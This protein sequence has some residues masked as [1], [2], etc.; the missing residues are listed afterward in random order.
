MLRVVGL[1]AQASLIA[2]VLYNAVTA[3]WGWP[4][5]RQAPAGPRTRQLRVVVPAHD[6]AVVLPG[7]LADLGATE[8]PSERLEVWVLA[9]RCR[10][11]TAELARAAGAE[12]D[13][14]GEGPPGKGPA[15]AW[16]LDRHPLGRG[17]V[18][19]VFDAD[20][21]VP[22]H[23]LA[24]IADEIDQGHTVVQCYLDATNPGASPLAEA[25]ALSYWAGNRMVQLARTNL[26]W[27][28]D[29]GG[30]G[31]AL[32]TEAIEAAGGFAD[33]LTEDQDLGV[34]LL[35][36][37]HR[38]EW[39]HDVRIRDEKPTTLA[40]TVRQRARWMAGKRAARRRHLLAL[41][42]RPT[43]ARIDMAVRLVQPGRSFVALLT[44][45][46]TLVAAL[47]S[48]HWMLPWQLWAAATLVQVLQPLPF[49]ARDGVPAPRIA[50][51]PLLVLLAALWV[52]IRVV[53]TRVTGW[54]HTPH[55][56]PTS[57]GE[58]ETGP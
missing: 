27:A 12:V 58:Q 55:T 49:L 35:L 5:R 18:L 8:Y 10:D 14:R 6:E 36:A 11:D 33:S 57:G 40:V 7:L 13:E 28:A 19:V 38:V 3:L 22:P 21:R 54:Y 34:R 56:G 48:P 50:R 25:A 45:G 39:L 31:M 44:A 32:T 16:H 43:P 23:T 24:R 37:G 53:S 46:L 15:L 52:P 1:I 26:G 41:L 47:F 51:Y 29:L 42:S 17:E 30:T 2:L 9:D 20:N 4:D